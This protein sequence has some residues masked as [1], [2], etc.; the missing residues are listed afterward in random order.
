[1]PVY[2]KIGLLT[3]AFYLGTLVA[4]EG[5]KE[6]AIVLLVRK[7]GIFGMGYSSQR[8]WLVWDTVFYGLIWLGCFL[9]A[10][11]LVWR[12]LPFPHGKGFHFQ[13]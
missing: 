4:I 6:I 12:T 1:M 9:L 10:R 3:C 5:A 8:A 13:S 11:Q 2:L 7:F